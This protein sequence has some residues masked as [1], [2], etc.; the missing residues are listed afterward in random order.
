MGYYIDFEFDDQTINHS[1]DVVQLFLTSG[2]EH[3]SFPEDESKE[4]VE[5]IEKE[6]VLL[7]YPGLNSLIEVIKDNNRVKNGRWAEIRFSWAD[8]NRFTDNLIK[9]IQ[10]GDKVGCKIYDGQID[11]YIYL[12]GEGIRKTKEVHNSGLSSV[13]RTLGISENKSDENI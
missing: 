8:Q 12:T 6:A 7:M 5:A 10:L 3:F 11:Q 9:I 2:A 13:S 1:D 4:Y